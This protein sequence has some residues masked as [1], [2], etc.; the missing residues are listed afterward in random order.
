ME[1]KWNGS[2]WVRISKI[3]GIADG[4]VVI[5]DFNESVLTETVVVISDAEAIRNS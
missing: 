3:A 5:A 4:S 2:T 1:F